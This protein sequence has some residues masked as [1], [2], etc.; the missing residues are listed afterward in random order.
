MGDVGHPAT[1]VQR[2]RFHVIALADP[3][4]LPR[5]I[6]QFA[7]R[8]SVPASVGMSRADGMLR[9]S[10]VADDLSVRD[11]ELLAATLSSAPLVQELTMTAVEEIRSPAEA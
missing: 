10:V 1:S 11:L 9:I 6:A 7:K 2:V 8:S 5:I 4:S 3:E